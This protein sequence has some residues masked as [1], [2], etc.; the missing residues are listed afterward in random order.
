MKNQVLKLSNSFDEDSPLIHCVFCGSE[1][2]PEFSDY[3]EHVTFIYLVE[4][5]V[6]EHIAPSFEPIVQKLQR[7]L[8]ETDQ[9]SDDTMEQKLLSLPGSSSSFV[10]EVGASGMA[11]GPTSFT[12][13][14]GFDGDISTE[15]A[16]QK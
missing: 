8:D 3:C 4:E 6:F 12:V 1:E 13:L 11:C 2:N 15:A 5:M 14:Y 7:E 9:E 16:P 10:I